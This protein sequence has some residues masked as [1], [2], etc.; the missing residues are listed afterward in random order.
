M[1]M[2]LRHYWKLFFLWTVSTAV[3]AHPHSYIDLKA[4]WLVTDNQLTGIA[5]DWQLDEITSLTLT[6][7]IFQQMP[8]P[9]AMKQIAEELTQNM[10]SSTFFTH[11]EQD[12]QPRV[13]YLQP[14]SSQAEQNKL[15][16]KFSFILNLDQPITLANTELTLTTYEPSY[17]V[18]MA[19]QNHTDIDAAQL[20][21]NCQTQLIEPNYNQVLQ[22]YAMSLDLGETADEDLNLGKQ[23]SQKVILK[24]Q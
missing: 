10:Q 24:C 19:F 2:G 18:S 22:D 23:F 11:L 14:N 9:Q 5:F 17:Y 21:P 6:Y 7:D 15:K 8:Y 20:P 1:N 12:R 3:I 13:L 16:T 4:K